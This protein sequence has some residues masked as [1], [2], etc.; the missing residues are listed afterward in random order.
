MA[1]TKILN[2]TYN[3]VDEIKKSPTYL[4][5]V[6]LDELIKEKYKNEL[7][8]YQNTFVKFDDVFSSGGT[9]HPNFIEISRAYKKAKEIF[10]NKEEVK[11]YF[12]CEKELN[13]LLNELSNE[14]S[15]SVSNYSELKGGICSWR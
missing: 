9:Y 13:D 5:M 2:K 8:D 7:L 14:I 15:N 10:F 4:K 12:L 1:Y 3:L 6:E 11:L